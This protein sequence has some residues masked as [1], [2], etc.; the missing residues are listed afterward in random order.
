MLTQSLLLT[1]F[2]IS[3]HTV[4][5]QLICSCMQLQLQAAVASYGRNEGLSMPFDG[6]ASTCSFPRAS[7]RQLMTNDIEFPASRRSRGG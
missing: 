6:P 3:K 2:F 5:R 4:P 1:Q 7:L